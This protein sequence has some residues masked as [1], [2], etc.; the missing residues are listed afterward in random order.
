MDMTPIYGKFAKQ[1]F[2]MSCAQ[3]SQLL[4]IAQTLE[5]SKSGYI[6]GN[7]Q[8][9]ESPKYFGDVTPQVVK[10]HDGASPCIFRVN[11]SVIW[12]GRG[13]T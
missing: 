1:S 2:H 11:R 6:A 10:G 4:A 5:M 9:N 7:A 8:T 13:A 12:R 3:H